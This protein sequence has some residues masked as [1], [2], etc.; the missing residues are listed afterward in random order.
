MNCD[1]LSAIGRPYNLANHAF[2]IS[3]INALNLQQSCDGSLAL[4][5]QA[6]LGC[7]AAGVN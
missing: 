4:L 2:N 1:C 6:P 5:W 7:F 3:F